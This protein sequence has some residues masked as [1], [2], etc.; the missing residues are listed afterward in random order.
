MKTASLRQNESI[1]AAARAEIHMK[2]V[3]RALGEMKCLFRL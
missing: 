1:Q 3:M 2:S